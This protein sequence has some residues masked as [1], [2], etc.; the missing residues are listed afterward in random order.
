M[1]DIK[2]PNPITQLSPSKIHHI[3]RKAKMSDEQIAEKI[4]AIVSLGDPNRKYELKERIGQGCIFCV[5]R[6]HL[7]SLSP[8]RLALSIVE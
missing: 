6:I 5:G 2:E 1:E 8:E 4:R 7:T 3:K